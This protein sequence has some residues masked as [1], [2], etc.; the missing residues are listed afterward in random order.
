[1]ERKS[2]SKG[3]NIKI[4][5]HIPVAVSIPKRRGPHI[6][7]QAT[8]GGLAGA[9]TSFLLYPEKLNSVDLSLK[10]HLPKGFMAVT[11]KGENDCQ[12]KADLSEL[13]FCQFIVGK[14]FAYPEGRRGKGF[15]LY[16]LGRKSDEMKQA[17]VW[18]EKVY[19]HLRNRLN[20]KAENPFRILSELTKEASRQWCRC[21]GGY[22]LYLPPP[23]MPP[24]PIF[25]P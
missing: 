11:S 4:D 15:S 21:N 25:T 18:V 16:A 23:K 13:M 12:I 6:D 3:K 8:G 7:L 14:M 2:T 19:A 24:P 9:F 20:G 22:T 10:W 17:A 5:Y 1:L